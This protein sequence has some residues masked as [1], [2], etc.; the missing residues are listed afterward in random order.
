MVN[1]GAVNYLNR[2]F[3]I[4]TPSSIVVYYISTLFLSI[5]FFLLF[6]KMQITFVFTHQHTQ[7]C[8]GMK[9][10]FVMCEI[11][12]YFTAKHVNKL[13]D[14]FSHFRFRY[15]NY[16]LHQLII[17]LIG[18][19]SFSQ[20]L[21]LINFCCRNVLFRVYKLVMTTVSKLFIILPCCFIFSSD[22][23]FQLR[24]FSPNTYQQEPQVCS[25]AVLS[26]I[27]QQHDLKFGNKAIWDFLC[28]GKAYLGEYFPENL[29]KYTPFSSG[30]LANNLW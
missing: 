12:N 26:A 7:Y 30:W 14:R 11:V 13:L 25:N 3:N 15:G 27:K 10:K 16:S 2:F 18:F 19:I 5:L 1:N 6:Y 23:F 8:S 20:H 28:W 29:K 17:L 21:S 24:S 9:R 22:K 4:F